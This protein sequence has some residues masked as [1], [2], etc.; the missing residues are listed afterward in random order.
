M[1]T[2]PLLLTKIK[3]VS[4]SCTAPPYLATRALYSSPPLS[5]TRPQIRTCPGSRNPGSA[6]GENL[7]QRDTQQEHVAPKVAL[8][9]ESIE[10]D[11]RCERLSTNESKTK[12]NTKWILHIA[13]LATTL[14]S[15]GGCGQNGAQMNADE[16]RGF[17][18]RYTEAWCSQNPASVAAFFAEDGSLKINDGEP[19]VGREAITRAAQGFMTA[20]P[21]MV[22]EMEDLTVDGSHAVYHWTLSGTNTGPGGTGNSVRISGF[23]EW[24]I[25]S[26]G[27]I[28]ESKGH[29]DEA[30]YARQLE[31]T[32]LGE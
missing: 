25:N 18:A 1:L 27:L 17:A 19:S 26:D 3:R 9:F 6:P 10:V 8:T 13:F 28:G 11:P 31:G 4:T 29:F 30:E 7:P 2:S 5:Y 21:D 12:M 24:T 14:I 22:V 32:R 23:E 15:L 16:L 20:F